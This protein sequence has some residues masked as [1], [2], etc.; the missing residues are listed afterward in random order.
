MGRRR[1]RNAGPDKP[2][3]GFLEERGRRWAAGLLFGT[4]VAILLFATFVRTDSPYGDPSAGV[5]AI[6]VDAEANQTA[7]VAVPDEA[8]EVTAEQTGTVDDPVG[9]TGAVS[10]A[11]RVM[12]DRERIASGGGEYTVQVMVACSPE[13]VHN[14]LVHSGG[15]ADLYVLPTVHQGRSCYL[16]SW[17][18][19]PTREAAEDARLPAAL[20]GAVSKTFVRRIA[21]L[22]S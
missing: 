18:V 13:T 20:R 19:Y 10:L 1:N 12:E 21:D 8:P 14:V 9:P 5:A 7:P 22:I 16:L 15:S 3:R 11:A 17:G 6:D 2:E 4:V